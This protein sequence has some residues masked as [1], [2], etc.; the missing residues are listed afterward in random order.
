[1]DVIRLTQAT[2]LTSPNPFVLVC[3]EKPNG[4]TN[5]AAVSWWT[6][7][8]FKPDMVG[9]A[10]SKKSYSGE[11]VQETGKVVLAVPG[12]VL[13]EQAMEC[14]C[15]S[16]RDTEKARQF[17]IEL[18]SI[19]GTD[20]MVPAH[21]RLAIVCDMKEYHE[22][23]D[24]FFYICEAKNVYGDETENA[25]YAWKGYAELHSIK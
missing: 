4:D 20:I 7:L 21:S 18:K 12:E 10:M 6:Y 15:T 19:A 24:H 17:D 16:G 5:L 9:F 8:S 13:A 2:K 1:M 11:R 23:G 14:G 3:T 25:I 22:V